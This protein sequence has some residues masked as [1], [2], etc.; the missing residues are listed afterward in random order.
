MRGIGDPLQIGDA[1]HDVRILHYD[2]ARFIVDPRDKRIVTGVGIERGQIVIDVL[3]RKASHGLG[4]GN[5]MRMHPAAHQDAVPLGQPR[6]HHDGLPACG[7]AIVHGGVGHRAPIEPRDLRLE[8][9]QHLQGA[10]RDFRLIR[11]IGGQELTAL[12]DVI[13]SRGHVMA[14]GPR[15][16]EKRR[17]RRSQI[18]L[19]QA[20]HMFFD[21][22]LAGVERKPLDR[23]I[24]VMLRW[25]IVEQRI[26]RRRADLF[27]HRATV[28]VGE[29]EVTHA[30]SPALRRKSCRR[31]RPSSLPVRRNRIRSYGRTI[32]RSRGWN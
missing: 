24:E 21:R 26:D 20:P 8:F 16:A 10:L 5:V 12:D 18:L 27:Q 9:E 29:G 19:R 1:T 25:H 2:A 32:L 15:T 23:S 22:H 11:R 13:D 28:D 30:L 7:G 3:R 17:V 6:R 14:I 4:Y 31:F